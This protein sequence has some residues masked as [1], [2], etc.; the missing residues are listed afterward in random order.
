MSVSTEALADLCDGKAAALF[1][2]RSR[3]CK[4]LAASGTWERS[5]AEDAV[6]SPHELPVPQAEA[7]AEEIPAHAW[8]YTTRACKA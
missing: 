5:E 7:R 3:Q 4:A 6:P 8:V 2:F 1:P